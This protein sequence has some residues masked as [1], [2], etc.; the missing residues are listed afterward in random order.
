MP[1][2]NCG[3]IRFDERQFLCDISGCQ[4]MAEW[5]G[6]IRSDGWI[7]W[8]QVC[9]SHKDRLEGWKTI[10]ANCRLTYLML[11]KTAG[12]EEEYAEYI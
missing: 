9:E 6:Y 11:L 3:Y 10:Y 12:I 2:P 5:E 4:S 7:R 1:C 8:S